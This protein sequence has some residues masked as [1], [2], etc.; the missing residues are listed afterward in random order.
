M[1]YK[2]Y[3]S[4]L[5]IISLLSGFSG[6]AMVAVNGLKA[7]SSALKSSLG[8]TAVY[9][10]D[11][12]N[13]LNFKEQKGIWIT[14]LEFQSILKNKTKEQFTDSI[15]KYFDNAKGM[16]INTV[17][18]HVRAFG[19]AYYH[20]ELF[21]STDNYNGTFGAKPAFDALEV[22]LKEAHDRGLSFH[23]WVNPMRLMSDD[24]MKALPN[25]YTVK[26]W[27]NS[28]TYRGHYIVKSGNRW[29]FNPAY[30]AVRNLIADG[31]AEIIRGYHVDGIQIDDYFYPT[32]A[33]SFDSAA[34]KASKT[35]L[36]LSDWRI[37]NVNGMVRQLYRTIKE[38]NP[39][40][41]FGISPQ[42][43]VENNYKE[44]Y[45][46][47]KTWV[48]SPGYCDYIL[49]QI[50][51]GFENGHLPYERTCREWRDMV[52]RKDVQLVFGL[53]AYKI[54]AADNYAGTG[55]SEWLNNSDI[56]ARQIQYSKTL[57]KYGGYAI[58]RYDSLFNPPASVA[59][60]A[61]TELANIKRL[62]N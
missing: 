7:D 36:S 4:V 1:F 29:Y 30:T 6:N 46:D 59:K 52:T 27:Y 16:G 35:T 44:L 20:S 24:E 40:V 57:E 51:Y 11:Q 53:A 3:V 32:T 47:V 48:T 43:S 50:Y 39:T 45:A 25:S 38:S 37:R 22:M 34:Y 61:E 13:A 55:R 12:Y 17:Y 9:P 5:L 42:G 23:A 49:P 15:G 41:V 31:I 26:K 2:C 18:V 58:F 60:Q 19:D 56:I 28:D 54:G 14:Y 62:N 33:A 10:Y 8:T 21:P